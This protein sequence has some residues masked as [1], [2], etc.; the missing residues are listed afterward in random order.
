MRKAG[1]LL[2][3]SSLMGEYGIGDFGASA[4]YFA[5]YIKRI[6]FKIWQI[7]PITILGLGNSP[8][9]GVS[10]FA[11]NALLIDI[12]QLPERLVSREEREECKIYSPY[13]VD[14]FGVRTKKMVALR[15][16]AERLNDE[17]KEAVAAFAKEN[18]FWLEDYALYMAIRDDIGKEWGEWD[19]KLKF[20]DKHA[21]K[22][23]RERL[24]ADVLYYE[25]EQYL[26]YTQ[27]AKL[28]EYVNSLGVEIFGDMPIYVAYNSPDVWANPSNFRLDKHLKPTEVAGVPPDY[29]AEDGQLWGN[30]LYNYET[31]EK[32]GYAWMTERIVH[33]LKMYDILRIDH[34]RGLCEYW[35][36][37]AE[38]KTA[39]EGK[40]R[41][42]PGMKLWKAVRKRV[43]DPQIVAEDLGIIDDK[44]VKYLE[45]TGFP[46]MR[47]LQFAFDGLK[48]NPHLPYN[49]PINT[50]AYTA[51]HDNN[52]SL[53]WL[54]TLDHG[55]LDKVLE[56]I[57]VSHSE[58]GEGGRHC[59]STQA[60]ARAVAAS[61]ARTVIFPL[62]DLTG[63]GGDT[64]LNV[65]GTPEGNWEFR[66]TLATLEDID[67]DF[68]RKLLDIYGRN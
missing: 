54:Y 57:D 32:D 5:D 22:E 4:R 39:K 38:A 56:F 11:G 18:A 44:V 40:W 60:M 27:W 41:A 52:T 46:G 43:K 13:R 17:D 26:F 7:L 45:E 42:G 21:L 59:K 25:F 30:P 51:T 35:A 8:Y 49:Y 37:P 29:F 1:V 2:P 47:V 3:V 12:T 36:V 64:R 24:S 33:N 66:A 34:F 19:D 55:T 9:S 63:Y 48:D 61:S 23:A 62:Q 16:A 58:W 10:A 67:T 53:G 20:R 15:R 28:K 65:P 6:G 50:V 31:M 14:Y 68:Y